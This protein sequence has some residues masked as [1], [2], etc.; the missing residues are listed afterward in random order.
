MKLTGGHG[1]GRNALISLSVLA[2]AAFSSILV[3]AAPVFALALII[4]R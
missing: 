2:G 1:S 4:V 3:L